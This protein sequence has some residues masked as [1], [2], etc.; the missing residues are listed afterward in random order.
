MLRKL[1]AV[2]ALLGISN[3]S[4]AQSQSGTLKG[5]I[6][7]FDTGESVPMANIVI[8]LNGTVVN[9]AVA[10]FD[11][12]YTIKPIDPGRYT[13]KVSFIGFATKEIRDVLVSSNKIT[14]INAG[15]KM[16]SDVLGE[17]E[18]VEYVVPLI[19]PDKTGTTLTKEAITALPT[20]DVQSVAAQTAGIYQED[21]G[22]ALNVRGARSDATFFYIDGVKVRASN[23]LPQSSIE[24]MTVITGGL[25]ASYGDAMGGVISITTRGPSN[26]FFGGMEVVSSSLLD[27]YGYN[28]VGFNLSGPLMKNEEGNSILGFFLS[29]EY[30]DVKDE[31]PSAVG[32]YKV[33]DAKMDELH[34]TPL[35]F[36]YNLGEV[37]AL[38]AA[39]FITMDDLEHIDAKQNVAKKSARI[40]GK[41]DFKPS[42]NTNITLGGNFSY[43][44]DRGYIY[45][46]SL[47]NPENN[48]ETIKNSWRIYSRLQQSFGASDD[49]QSSS[50]LKNAFFTLQADY[51][52]DNQITQDSDHEDNLFNYGY[53]GKFTPERGLLQSLPWD[54]SDSLNVLWN[55]LD[56]VVEVGGFY[57]DAELDQNVP[58][59]NFVEQSNV[60][61]NYEFEAANLNPYATTYTQSYFDFLG[62]QGIT[63]LAQVSGIGAAVNGDRTEDVYSLWYNTGRE[64][65]GYSK[66]KDTQFRFTGSASADINDHAL[67]FGFEYEQRDDRYYGISPVGL[68]TL[69]QQQV[70]K[71]IGLEEGSYEFLNDQGSLV[72]QQNIINLD[73]MTSFATKFRDAHDIDDDQIVDIHTYL[74]SDFDISMFSS[75][76]LLTQNPNSSYGSWYGYDSNGNKLEGAQPGMKEFLTKKDDNGDYKREMGA[77]QPIYVSGYIQDKFA[78]EDLIFNIGVRVDRYDA[79][80]EVLKDKYSI[81]EVLSAGEVSDLGDH[82]TNIGDEYV[83][84]V[85][86][87]ENASFI[88]GYRNGD[89]WYNAE[90]LP[91][92]D[93]GVL[94]AST[95]VIPMLAN[96]TTG[97]E[98]PLNAGLSADAF[99]DYT[100]QVS[101]MPRISFNFPISDEAIFYAHYD[102]LTQRPSRNRMD[103]TDYLFLAH[104]T[105]STINNPNLKSQRTTDYELGFK[106]TLSASS[107]ISISSFYREMRDM[108]QYTRVAFAYPREYFTYGN[109]DFGTVKGLSLAYEMRRTNNISF[110]ANYT[111]QFADGSGSSSTS[112]VDIVNSDQ[113]NLRTTLPLDYDQRHNLTASIDFRYG[114][115]NKY[116]GPTVGGR[117]ILENMGVNVVATAGSGTPFSRQLNSTREAMFG[118]NDRTNLE[119]SVNGSR[120]P[121][122]YRLDLRVNKGFDISWGEGEEMKSA[123]M[124]VY[125]QVQN[126]LN[127]QNLVTVY[128]YTGNADD[129]GYLNSAVGVNATQNQVDP[130]AFNDLYSLKLNNPNNYTRPRTVRLGVTLDF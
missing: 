111:L 33:K 27:P 23:K 117:P 13:V 97:A 106:Q 75:D 21:E 18:L 101:F 47:F 17:V 19:D 55:G 109:I 11:G 43:S 34:D 93:P 10:D 130:T 38:R 85:N 31:D 107:A 96:S 22:G 46:Y 95:G 48:P 90:G 15:L 66:Y 104:K 26:E 32:M 70:N 1:L 62:N 73:E 41:I 127:T 36:S 44:K 8:E 122:R 72:G 4:I 56:T 125:F 3:Y 77:F 128:Q 79:N 28:L 37:E 16:E 45:T 82:P 39:E 20:R 108:I 80:Q 119:G 5:T 61:T 69:A 116:N 49:E 52:V 114:S 120:L 2:I 129:D 102:V 25:P 112:G 94:D 81:F 6:T 29:G 105:A 65:N 87:K 53:I 24:Q 84:Y 7:E 64:Y 14:F 74:P 67:Q 40:Q 118:I 35:L 121:W 42:K 103:P 9:G 123:S 30:E 59:Y 86:A 91:I 71:Y 58:F 110:N 12:K 60:I 126:L 99:E 57:Y 76:E 78:F 115:G 100:P 113:P 98:D 63:S 54:P 88:T 89:N 92:T 51:S 83:V 50:S 68:W 124:N